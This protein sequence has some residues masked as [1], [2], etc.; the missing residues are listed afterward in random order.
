[1]GN[2]GEK[3]GQHSHLYHQKARVSLVIL[4]S[5]CFARKIKLHC[6]PPRSS[7]ADGGTL[8]AHGGTKNMTRI[9]FVEGFDPSSIVVNS[10]RPFS[11]RGYVARSRATKIGGGGRFRLSRSGVR[12]AVRRS[13][14]KVPSDRAR[15]V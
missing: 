9:F 3:V 13:R 14:R 10:R 12:A 5:K 2:P 6:P 8:I 7:W 4:L 1:M 15:V 11:W